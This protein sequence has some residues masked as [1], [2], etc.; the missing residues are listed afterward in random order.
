M[1][2]VT[3]KTGDTS[4]GT[5]TVTYAEGTTTVIVKEVP[6]EICSLCGAYYLDI[7]TV[8]EL[9]RVVNHE[10]QMGAEITVVKLKKAA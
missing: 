3:C 6:A 8:E 4:P 10:K 9:R 7:D 2:C 5:T 1:K